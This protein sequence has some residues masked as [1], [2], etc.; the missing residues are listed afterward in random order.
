VRHQPT[1]VYLFFSLLLSITPFSTTAQGA[2]AQC[3][4][5]IDRYIQSTRRLNVTLGEQP[6]VQEKLYEL[7]T[8]LTNKLKL[9][10]GAESVRKGLDTL[11][12]TA[13]TTALV[14]E[15]IEQEQWGDAVFN[16]TSWSVNRIFSQLEEA[17]E[18]Q[19]SQHQKKW[20]KEYLGGLPKEERAKAAKALAKRLE[21][22]RAALDLG[23]DVDSG[24]ALAELNAGIE[25]GELDSIDSLWTHFDDSMIKESIKTVV[26]TTASH[27]APVAITMAV[28]DL[29]NEA[30]AAGYHWVSNPKLEQMYQAYKTARADNAAWRDSYD[31]DTT[32]DWWRNWDR[33]YAS[34]RMVLTKTREVMH[35]LGHG[36]HKVTREKQQL[37]DEQV[38]QFLFQ[39]FDAWQQEEKQRNEQIPGLTLANNS[40]ADLKEINCHGYIDQARKPKKEG[41]IEKARKR[42]FAPECEEEIERFKYY[43]AEYLKVYSDLRDNWYQGGKCSDQIGSNGMSQL[44]IKAKFITCAKI[45]PY[46]EQGV[47]YRKT[48]LAAIKECGWFP[49]LQA[50]VSGRYSGGTK[51]VPN[52]TVELTSSKIEVNIDTQV[53]KNGTTG[54]DG[55]T[56]FNN[57]P[58]GEYQIMASAEGF[59]EKTVDGIQLLGPQQHPYRTR[60]TLTPLAAIKGSVLNKQSGAPVA[61]ARVA[62][63]N[64]DWNSN[65]ETTADG[66]F[67]L[68][69]IPQGTY[70]L[71]ASKQ[72]FRQSSL[73]NLKVTQPVGA[74]KPF[75][76][77][78]KIR[79]SPEGATFKAIILSHKDQKPIP[80][81]Q[82]ALTSDGFSRTGSSN[83]KGEV[84]LPDIPY[85]TY[86]ISASAGGHKKS[87]MSGFAMNQPTRSGK[88]RLW[89]LE[90]ETQ[91]AAAEKPE[92]KPKQ[93]KKRDQTPGDAELHALCQCVS[94]DYL[95]NSTRPQLKKDY[96][97]IQQTV[98]VVRAAGYNPASKRCVGRWEVRT[99]YDRYSDWYLTTWDWD[100][101]RDSNPPLYRLK[102]EDPTNRC[103]TVWRQTKSGVVCWRNAQ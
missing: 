85:G 71:S 49:N 63:S 72:G 54:P 34:D 16:V 37:S 22:Y 10:G 79:L 67:E 98:K 91:T 35:A 13:K 83:R 68:R 28:R 1:T 92:Q 84:I 87:V 86:S 53:S 14:S 43:S 45:N 2:D 82:V 23:K 36:V 81:A 94:Q 69:Q 9:K 40:Y 100:T 30:A 44:G 47:E 102:K 5:E 65:T 90:E 6:Q 64:N 99:K 38:Y 55:T 26:V 24:K 51:P 3:S 62:L 19:L 52:A 18:G 60:V 88:I 97:K 76:K 42:F 74:D 25:R 21:T 95:D 4:A 89:P 93:T 17:P 33:K 41:V 56:A 75:V 20:F 11:F 77:S 103:C 70:T 29:A 96:P 31:A 46:D 48:Y 80:G 8:V 15:N 66:S 73:P 27:W 61:G 58:L 32:A 50:K 57:L 39:Q 78:G 101:T 7:A 12:D 59:A